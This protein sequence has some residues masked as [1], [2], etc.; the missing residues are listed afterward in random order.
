MAISRPV[1][2]YEVA[3]AALELEWGR[4]SPAT[5]K[6]RY[7]RAIVDALANANFLRSERIGPS[8]QRGRPRVIPTELR[9]RIQRDWSAGL[10]FNEIARRLNLEGVPAATGRWHHSSVARIAREPASDRG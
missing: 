9:R 6:Q 7:A 1:T 4:G 5:Y 2:A 8:R 10:S 3:L